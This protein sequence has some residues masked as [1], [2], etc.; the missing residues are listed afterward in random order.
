MSQDI[1]LTRILD[2]NRPSDFWGRVAGASEESWNRASI[3]AAEELG[4]TAPKQLLGDQPF[5]DLVVS[6]CLGEGQ[7]GPARYHLSP[8]KS[9]YYH[10]ARPFLPTAARALLRS[11]W[12][13]SAE[14]AGQL[15]WPIEDRY[16]HYL[17]RVLIEVSVTTPDGPPLSGLWPEDARFAFVL[18]HDVEGPNGLSFVPKL[19]EIDGSYGFKSSFN[20]VPLGYKVDPGLLDEI[21]SAGCE[22]GVHG[23]RHDG[24]LFTSESAFMS[25]AREINFWL[26]RWESVGFRSPMTHRNPLWMQALEIDYDSSWFDTDPYEPMPGGCMSIWPFHMGRFVELPY[27]LPQDHTLL[28]TLGERSPR[29]WIDKTMFI[30][31]HRGMALL[32]S[33]PDYLASSRH[34]EVYRQFLE[35]AA[36]LD[37]AWRALPRDVARWWRR[38]SECLRR[39]TK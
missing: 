20:F 28:V 3:S 13:L 33:H 26:R 37:D 8:L 17:E 12:R 34:L 19:L 5:A 11:V 23:L 7:F 35:F 1:D 25:Q 2:G 9:F 24:R 4:V 16:V 21:R 31:N 6:H 10:W 15:G 29:L 32:N 36:G 38:R 22:V 39:T 30:R 14:S 18:T 27:T